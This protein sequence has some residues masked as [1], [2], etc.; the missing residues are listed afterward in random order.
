M[1]ERTY[2]TEGVILKRINFGEAD[3]I[4]TILTK[5]YGK[6]RVRAPGIRRVISRKAPHLELFNHSN[7]FIAQGKNLDIVTEAQ[8][9]NSF[10]KIRKDLNKIETAFYLVELVD[11][12]CPERQ[13][14]HEVFTLLTETLKNLEAGCYNDINHYGENF[15]SELLGI[16]GFLPR[17]EKM[18]GEELERFLTNLIGKNLKSHHLLRKMDL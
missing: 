4:L 6:I 11:K 10:P 8:T 16:L 7:L 9:I 15:A 12:L 3:R 1:T 14:N 18:E 5:H 17:G 2:K 13:E